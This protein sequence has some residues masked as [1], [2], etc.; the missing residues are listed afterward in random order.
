MDVLFLLV[1]GVDVMRTLAISII[2]RKLYTQ[3]VLEAALIAVVREII[4]SEL[5][6]RAAMDILLF[7]VV[8][9]VLVL[10]ILIAKKYL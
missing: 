6:H 7:S 2:E 8:I 3:A 10:S 4:S 1:I 9:L 5:R